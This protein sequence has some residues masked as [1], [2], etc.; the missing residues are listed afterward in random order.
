MIRQ[1]SLLLVLSLASSLSF[2]ESTNIQKANYADNASAETNAGFLGG[3]TLG[4]TVGGPPGAI[5]GAAVGAL[6][7]DGWAARKQ[8]GALQVNLVNTRLELTSLQEEAASLRQQYELALSNNT[9]RSARVIPTRLE[10]IG[11]NTCCDNTVI[12]LYF[13]TGSTAIEDHQHEV[14]SSFARLSDF[15]SDPLIEITGYADR[16][17]NADSN[18]RLSQQRT[19]EVKSLLGQLG[20]ENTSI[21]T[22]AY[23]ESRPLS[24]S[25]SLE[26]DFFDR[27]VILRLRDRSQVM[28]TRSEDD[29]Q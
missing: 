18:L 1:I 5:V 26:T 11:T 15:I 19:R 12:S 27:R 6:L 16:N 25:Q 28:L 10:T 7:G 29:T 24:T 13:R 8:V 3:L 9:S 22:I 20:M 23:G 4:A 17:G 14:I 21:T 2:A